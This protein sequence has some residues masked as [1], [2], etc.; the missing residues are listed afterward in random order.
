MTADDL[1]PLRNEELL[2]CANAWRS[3]DFVFHERGESWVYD[4]AWAEL[5]SSQ[6]TPSDTSWT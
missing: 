6:M 2:Y 4:A 1:E 3:A 5:G